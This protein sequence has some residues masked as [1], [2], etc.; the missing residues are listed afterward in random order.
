VVQGQW[1]F[2]TPDIPPDDTSPYHRWIYSIYRDG[3]VYIECSGTARTENFNPP[4]LGMVFCC[5][6]DQGFKRHISENKPQYNRN[7]TGL[8]SYV[9]FSRSERGLADLLIAP[10]EPA[11]LRVL[12]SPQ[13]PRLCVL[14]NLPIVSDGFAFSAMLRVWPADIDSTQKADPLVD[15]YLNTKSIVVDTGRL[16]RTDPGDFNNDGFSEARGYHVLQLDGNVAK[17][18]ID[19]TKNPRYSPVFKLVDV[20]DQDI[21]VYLDGRLIKEIHRD[22]NDNILFELPEMIS[23]SALLEI[24]SMIREKGTP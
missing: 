8:Q 11:H 15:D 21:W 16:V 2:G 10:F 9:L 6:G 5:D 13:D 19:A 24:T 1:R 4:A 20:A 14:W 12:E 23:G 7:S 18:H 22:Q 17:V 3:R